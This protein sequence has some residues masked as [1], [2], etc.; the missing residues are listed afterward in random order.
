MTVKI[1]VIVSMYNIEKYLEE[2]IE[3]LIK[4]DLKDI[5][6][7][8]VNDG[9][10][11]GTL[12]IA[13]RYEKAY[14]NIRIINKT[15]GGLS[16]ARNVGLFYAKGE[17]VS[18]IDGDDY[19]LP[20]MFEL[21]YQSAS[22][23]NSDMVMIG[24]SRLL[25]DGS[26]IIDKEMTKQKLFTSKKVIKGN[27]VIKN[28]VLAPMLGVLP[29]AENDIELNCCVWRNIYRKSIFDDYGIKFKSEREYISEDLVFHVELIP[30]LEII[31]TVCEPTYVYRFNPNSLTKSYRPDRFVKECFLYESLLNLI[32]EMYFTTN[33]ELRLKRSF[34]GRIRTC[35]LSEIY[36]NK[37]D[38]FIMKIQ[39][40]KKILKNQTVKKVL[41]EYPINE[42]N[43]KLK[44]FTNMMKYNFSIGLI[45]LGIVYK[46]RY[47]KK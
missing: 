28:E 34:I 42:L 22:E 23:Y 5:E 41:Y 20:S 12:E 14:S 18:F 36:A 33:I 21:M 47:F 30:H 13:E 29:N 1:S 9:S 4:Q 16:S 19:I 17:Y 26:I 39:N 35:I 11:D 25:V 27:E 37:K 32:S 43:I 46:T 7:I 8:L 40:I 2:C 38:T 15:N 24:Y 45:G 6:I 44:V 10:T 31:S 3:S